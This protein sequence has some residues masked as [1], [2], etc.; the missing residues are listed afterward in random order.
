LAGFQVTTIGRFW[1]TAEVK[2]PARRSERATEGFN[3]RLDSTDR[4]VIALVAFVSSFQSGLESARRPS[5]S[6]T[7]VRGSLPTRAV[8]A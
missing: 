1:V 6:T 2:R 3:L 5:R 4:V 7:L 8:P